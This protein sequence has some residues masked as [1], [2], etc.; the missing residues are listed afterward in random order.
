MMEINAFLRGCLNLT[1]GKLDLRKE[2][3][4]FYIARKKTTIIDVPSAKFLAIT[5]LGEPRGSDY[6]A[7]IIVLYSYALKCKAKGRDFTVMTLDG[8]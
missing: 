1:L 4:Q 8:L 3:K 6:Q 7:A 2:F 5:G